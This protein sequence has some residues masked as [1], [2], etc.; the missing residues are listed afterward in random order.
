MTLSLNLKRLS[1]VV[2]I[3]A[4]AEEYG[5]MLFLCAKSIT[6]AIKKLSNFKD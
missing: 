6:C 2:R 5:M 4:S 3:F 1:S